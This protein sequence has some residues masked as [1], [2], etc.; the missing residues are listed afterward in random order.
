[1]G[2]TDSSDM[3]NGAA[4]PMDADEYENEEV[5]SSDGEVEEVS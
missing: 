1:M 5:M 2:P 4:D 3:I